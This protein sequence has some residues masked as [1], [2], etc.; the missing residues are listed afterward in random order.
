MAKSEG[1]KHGGKKKIGR[2]C[3]KTSQQ[4]YNA[5]DT[6]TVH[7]IKRIRQSCGEEFLSKWERRHY[8]KNSI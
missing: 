7:K 6:R 5:H 2:S 4:K 3:R 1:K 8:G